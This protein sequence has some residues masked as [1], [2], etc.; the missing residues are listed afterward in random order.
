MWSFS[1]TSIIHPGFESLPRCN[2]SCM[3]FFRPEKCSLSATGSNKVPK[4]I[5]C[6]PSLI[7]LYRFAI[8]PLQKIISYSTT[9]NFHSL[10]MEKLWDVVIIS[11]FSKK[12]FHRI[13]LTAKKCYSKAQP[14]LSRPRLS[15]ILNIRTRWTPENTLLRMHLS[16]VWLHI[17]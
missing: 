10:S 7:S 1:V 8:T 9:G 14:R 5:V 2:I 13:L 6:M 15:G 11:Q 17:E 4:T 3:Y 16:W 12:I